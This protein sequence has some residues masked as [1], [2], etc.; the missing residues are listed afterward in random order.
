[1]RSIVTCPNLPHLW[2][3]LSLGRGSSWQTLI[4]LRLPR[5]SKAF[6]QTTIPYCHWVTNSPPQPFTGNTHRNTHTHRY[7]HIET[8]SCC[9]PR[10]TAYLNLS[11]SPPALSS[12]AVT[13]S[14]GWRKTTRPVISP[15]YPWISLHLPLEG[16]T[17]RDAETDWGRGHMTVCTSMC[18]PK[19]T[20][21][22]EFMCCVCEFVGVCLPLTFCCSI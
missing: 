22:T 16:N 13:L 11:T 19:W 9:G 18:A 1:M 12:L 21:L 8:H 3:P 6:V 5:P 7:C 4:V 17:A 14:Y 2:M 15:F 10:G 20:S